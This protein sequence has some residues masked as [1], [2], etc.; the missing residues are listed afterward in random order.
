[1]NKI[2]LPPYEQ[3]VLIFQG[4]GS[5]GAYQAGVYEGMA[6]AGIDPTWVAGISIGA[7][8][9]AIVAGNP[10]EKRVERLRDFWETVCRPPSMSASF[11]AEAVNML[12]FGFAPFQESVKH[13][14]DKDQPHPVNPVEE[15]RLIACVKKRGL[16][17]RRHGQRRRVGIAPVFIALDRQAHRP[18][19]RRRVLA[20]SRRP[21][22]M[23]HVQ[24]CKPGLGR[25]KFRLQ[26]R[27]HSTSA[28]IPA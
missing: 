4:G 9:A 1:M 2:Q 27:H 25:V 16:N 6:E 21:T 18:Q 17:R 20:C 5:L 7:I 26:N 8:N 24:R 22:A 3:I 15:R 14:I 19:S 13:T 28:R 12:G 11:A 23:R 10:A